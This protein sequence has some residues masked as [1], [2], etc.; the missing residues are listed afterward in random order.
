VHCLQSFRPIDRRE[1]S[2]IKERPFAYFSNR[3]RQLNRP[4]IVTTIEVDA[5]IYGESE[6]Q[7]TA[8]AAGQKNDNGD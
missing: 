1:I 8:F 4:Q 5:G 7:G 3:V 2:A 6:A